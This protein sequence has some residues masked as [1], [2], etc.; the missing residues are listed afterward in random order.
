M[1]NTTNNTAARAVVTLD[2]AKLADMHIVRRNV[3]GAKG[4]CQLVLGGVEVGMAQATHVSPSQRYWDAKLNADI[5]GVA[6]DL[7]MGHVFSAVRISKAMEEAIKYALTEGKEG[8]TLEAQRQGNERLAL[9]KAPKPAPTPEAPAAE[10]S[11]EGGEGQA[12]SETPAP[13][14]QDKPARK[15]SGK[16]KEADKK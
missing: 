1:T 11:T 2:V 15:G 4:L 7:E 16:N 6:V 12:Q 8:A 14:A 13:E 9:F 10:G 5:N 3:P